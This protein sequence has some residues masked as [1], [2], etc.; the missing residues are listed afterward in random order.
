MQIHK[1]KDLIA[2]YK[3]PKYKYFISSPLNREPIVQNTPT[4]CRTTIIVNFKIDISIH[5]T[6]NGATKKL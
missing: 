6:I 5:I 1:K 3:P 2:I 4:D